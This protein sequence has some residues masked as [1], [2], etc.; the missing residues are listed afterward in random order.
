MTLRTRTLVRPVGLYLWYSKRLGECPTVHG[1]AR[2][3]SGERA[4]GRQHRSWVHTA[5][6]LHSALYVHCTLFTLHCMYYTLC[7]VCA[8]CT[9][10]FPLLYYTVCNMC[11]LLPVY[12]ALHIFYTVCALYTALGRTPRVEVVVDKRFWLFQ[13]PQSQQ[14]TGNMVGTSDEAQEYTY[15]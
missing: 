2:L 3:H 7:I 11:V 6:S 14:T 8:V 10:N 4:A 1:N 12:Y 9:I 13:P 5:L 15:H